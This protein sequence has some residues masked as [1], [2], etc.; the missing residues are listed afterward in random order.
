MSKEKCNFCNELIKDGDTVIGGCD[1][2]GGNM[3]EYHL[4]CY[5]FVVMNMG[6][7]Q[8][9]ETFLRWKPEFENRRWYKGCICTVEEYKQFKKEEEEL[10]K[11]LRK[12]LDDGED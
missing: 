8:A 7:K 2:G 9:I 5:E 1:K 12:G 11:H 6:D 3:T 4:D 10:L